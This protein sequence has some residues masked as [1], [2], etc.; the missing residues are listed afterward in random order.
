MVKTGHP[1][2]AVAIVTETFSPAVI[3]SLVPPGR[4]EAPRWR[5]PLTPT[6][7]PPLP[8]VALASRRTGTAVYGL[9]TLAA[10]GRL[11]DNKIFGALGWTA[12]LRLDIRQSTNLILVAADEHG[13]F[14]LTTLGRLHLPASARNWCRLDTGDRLLLAAYPEGGLL[15]VH[16]PAALDAV[17]DRVYGEALE[18]ERR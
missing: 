14:G 11:A 2:L 8:L 9:V 4:A 18:G 15:V 17:V 12:G 6:R 13:I 1:S 16:S 5:A 10:N 7:R 3:P